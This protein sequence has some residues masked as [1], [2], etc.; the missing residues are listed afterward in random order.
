MDALPPPDYNLK[1]PAIV[2]QQKVPFVKKRLLRDLGCKYGAT[3]ALSARA[4][5]IREMVET[6]KGTIRSAFN[7][8]VLL[9][10]EGI[11]PP[12]V[13][14]NTGRISV[15][16]SGTRKTVTRVEYRIVEPAKYVAVAPT[17]R[18]YLYRGLNISQPKYESSFLPKN[19]DEKVVWENAADDC[20]QKGIAQADRIFTTNL[21]ELTRDYNGR[22]LYILMTQLDIADKIISSTNQTKR[23]SDGNELILDKQDLELKNQGRLY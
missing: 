18:D 20:W 15:D 14:K 8:G 10:K 19:N 6:H 3:S 7:F 13:E 11:L 16:A 4:K 21:S 23:Y 17:W 5:Q 9:S 22:V 1:P 12:V 2:Q